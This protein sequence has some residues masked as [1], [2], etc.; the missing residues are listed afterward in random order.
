[1]E[2]IIKSERKPREAKNKEVSQKKSSYLNE[3][4]EF[5]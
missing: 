2:Y 4:K 3:L 1:M 5:E